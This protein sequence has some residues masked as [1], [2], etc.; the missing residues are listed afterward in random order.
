[1]LPHSF[2]TLL[3]SDLNSTPTRENRFAYGE[4]FLPLAGPAQDLAFAHRASITAARR[5]EDYSD[6]GSIV[7]P[8]LGFVYAPAPELSLGVSWGRSFK[9]PTLNQQYSGYTPVLLPVTGYG[10]LFPPGPTY[11]YIGGPNPDVGPEPPGNLA[12]SANFQSWPR[13]QKHAEWR[14]GD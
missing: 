5:W 12:P 11:L 8:K 2:H 13:L 6:S 7:T 1:M 10:T 14:G 9:M 3:S 4:R